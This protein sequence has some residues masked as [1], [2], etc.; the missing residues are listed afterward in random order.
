MQERRGTC[1]Y[2]GRKLPMPDTICACQMSTTTHS[3][4]TTRSTHLHGSSSDAMRLRT[5]PRNTD[6][7]VFHITVALRRITSWARM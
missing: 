2:S 1:K 4:A 7:A 5:K 3:S 6:A